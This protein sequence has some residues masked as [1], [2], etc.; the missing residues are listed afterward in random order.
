MNNKTILTDKTSSS[1]HTEEAEMSDQEIMAEV[2]RRFPRA[3]ETENEHDITNLALAGR[4]A[5]ERKELGSREAWVFAHRYDTPI[6]PPGH[7]C[8]PHE[9]V[10]RGWIPSD[11]EQSPIVISRWPQGTHFYASVH[12]ESVQDSE[13]N[14]KWGTYEQAFTAALRASEYR[15]KK[16][17]STQG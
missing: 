16:A 11:S 9:M 10:R 6:V 3:V 4:F 17:V 12:G 14:V 8:H 13:G 5:W 7:C 2:W 1:N 15:S